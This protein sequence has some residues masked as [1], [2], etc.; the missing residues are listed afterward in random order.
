MLSEGIRV[1]ACV[2]Q[3][4]QWWCIP[5][6]ALAVM[7]LQLIPLDAISDNK[8]LAFFFF[9]FLF[10]FFFFYDFPSTQCLLGKVRN[11]TRIKVAIR[12]SME[13]YFFFQI[14]ATRRVAASSELSSRAES[15]TVIWH[16]RSPSNYVLGG[17]GQFRQT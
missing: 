10:S 2:Q 6:G 11:R 12:R 4:R 13:I 7:L 15:Q 3:Q 8:S 1:A 16:D 17:R 5:S 9:F 14:R